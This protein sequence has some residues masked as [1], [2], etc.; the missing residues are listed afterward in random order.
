M[1]KMPKK[2][3]GPF[4]QILHML[5]EKKE[6]DSSSDHLSEKCFSFVAIKIVLSNTIW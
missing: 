1:P 2:K 5:S 3:S 6:F 4:G